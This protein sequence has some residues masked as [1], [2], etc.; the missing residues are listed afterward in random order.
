MASGTAVLAP[1]NVLD[2]AASALQGDGNQLSLNT[3]YEAI[4][5][6][7]HACMSAVDF[8]LVGL[9]EEHNLGL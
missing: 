5:V 1:D 7:G 3:P 8:R 6:V 2:L 4:A 9:G